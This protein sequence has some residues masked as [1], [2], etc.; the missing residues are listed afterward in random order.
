M[1]PYFCFFIT[2]AAARVPRK[3]RFRLT[4][5]T[6]SHCSTVISSIAGLLI[7]A[8][9]IQISIRQKCFTASLT[10]R[11]TSQGSETSSIA[12]DLLP[13]CSAFL[14]TFPANSLSMSATMTS[15]PFQQN[16]TNS[17]PDPPSFTSYKANFFDKSI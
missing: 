8:L 12:I 1:R 2:R 15:T 3:V 5:M 17:L 9:F 7:P 14:A 11:S 4:S 6:R 16:Q 13:S 10:V